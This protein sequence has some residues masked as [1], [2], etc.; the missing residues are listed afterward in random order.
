MKLI[1]N[2]NYL[3][4]VPENPVEEAYLKQLISVSESDEDVIKLWHR[5]NK[6]TESQTYGQAEFF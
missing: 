2:R 6:W 3:E 5:K 1:C 4:I